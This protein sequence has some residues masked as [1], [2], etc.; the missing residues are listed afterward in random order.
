MT[1][2]Q[3]LVDEAFV[4]RFEYEDATVLAADVGAAEATV[5]VVDDTVIVVADGDQYEHELPADEDARAFINNGVLT[6]ELSGRE[7][8]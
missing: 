7:E 8:N 2:A 4:R 5:D 3:Q 6:V 1:T